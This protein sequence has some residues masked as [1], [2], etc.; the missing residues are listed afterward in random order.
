MLTVTTFDRL[1]N[2]SEEEQ[3]SVEAVEISD[4]TTKI[5]YNRKTI[6]LN[7]C[8]SFV[9]ET[10][11]TS[12]CVENLIL[13][14]CEFFHVNNLKV[15]LLFLKETMEIAIENSSFKELQT[16]W[17]RSM[18]IEK[19]KFCSLDLR[20]A[21]EVVNL[22]EVE[23]ENNIIFNRRVK[24]VT[25]VNVTGDC[26]LIFG[27]VKM[28]KL[29]N[30]KFSNIF[31]SKVKYITMINCSVKENLIYNPIKA[32]FENNKINNIIGH[33]EKEQK[34]MKNVMKIYHDD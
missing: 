5:V 7:N 26:N 18:R 13:F 15:D 34:L 9:I 22:C 33:S 29:V 27:K 14:K 21:T 32:D 16:G 23:V 30:S 1:V 8:L 11:G 19:A 6:L 24:H 25:C 4:T 3:N 2:L 20:K 31:L 28:L 17:T 12:L 10:K